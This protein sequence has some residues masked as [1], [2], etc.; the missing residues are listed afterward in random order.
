MQ[1]RQQVGG[2]KEP[3]GTIN[4]SENG[5]YNVKNYAEA[6]VNI[7]NDF[8]VKAGISNPTTGNTFKDFITEI[9]NINIGSLTLLTSFF[10][11]YSNLKSVE[12]FDTSNVTS[13]TY[14]FYRNLNLEDVPLFNTSK[15]TSM[16]DIFTDCSKLTD[17]SLNNILAMAA[18]SIVTTTANKKISKLGLSQAQAVRCRTLSNYQAFINAGW[19]DDLQ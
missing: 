16:L 4:I 2:G 9:T 17:A 18:N 5:S 13:M 7:P 6:N 10:T 1:N 11:Q 8:N 14:M 15:V 3:T 19:V 12:L